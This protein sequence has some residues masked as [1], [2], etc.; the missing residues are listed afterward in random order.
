LK[1]VGKYKKLLKDAADRFWMFA[2]STLSPAIGTSYE[3]IYHVVLNESPLLKLNESLPCHA[4]F[5]GFFLP[6]FS[7][8]FMILQ[9]KITPNSIVV[10]SVSKILIASNFSNYSNFETK[11]DTPEKHKIKSLD[12]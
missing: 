10:L 12:F 6:L 7:S 5:L 4:L 1:S 3:L 2:C 9:L 11:G 8:S